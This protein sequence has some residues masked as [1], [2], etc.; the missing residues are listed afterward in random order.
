MFTRGARAAAALLL[1]LPGLCAA[2]PRITG[3]IGYGYDSNAN[4]ARR[5]GDERESQQARAALAADSTWALSNTTG[6]LLQGGV[7]SQQDFDYS[8][9]SNVKLTGLARVFYRANGG[10]YTPTF[11]LTGAAAYWD[12][13]SRQRDSA[14]Y[15]ASSHLTEQLTTRI[16]ARLGF[17]AVWREARGAVF[18][19]DS[20]S[21][22]L[23][24]D[25]NLYPRLALYLGYQYREGDLISTATIPA[26]PAAARASAP[27]DA[28]KI[29]GDIVFRVAADAQVGTLGFNYALSPQ[30]SLDVQ[31]QFIEAEADLGTRYERWLNV[32]GLLFRF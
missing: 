26:A 5:G 12:F 21:V 17:S 13:G 2:E 28:F 3:E 15:R 27:D 30:F 32:A 10:F 24:I 11:V 14:E 25:W 23:D 8:G 7:E 4:R 29:P 9:L 22:L 18:D 20:R 16:S 1:L 6:V 31:G 19:L